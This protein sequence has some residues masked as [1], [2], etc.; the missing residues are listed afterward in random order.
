MCRALQWGLGPNNRYSSAVHTASTAK[1]A[2]GSNKYLC[3]SCAWDREPNWKDYGLNG[4]TK[5]EGHLCPFNTLTGARYTRTRAHTH[6]HTHTHTQA[7]AHTPTHTSAHTP[8]SL[9]PRGIHL[10]ALAGARTHARARIHTLA[11]SLVRARPC[12]C[13]STR[14]CACACVYV[15]ACVCVCVC[16]CVFI[17]YAN[18]DKHARTHARA[19]ARTHTHTRTHAHTHMHT[20]TR[21]QSP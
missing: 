19:H 11:R 18:Q 6:A 10:N 1:M 14:G 5:M 2:D 9:I 3:R 17:A 20:H 21:T 12:I 16:V 13:Q 4:I 7:R 15:C 8:H